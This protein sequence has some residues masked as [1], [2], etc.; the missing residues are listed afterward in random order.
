MILT[1]VR[2]V[3]R[4]TIS[5]LKNNPKN[6]QTTPKEQPLQHKERVASRQRSEEGEKSNSSA[7]E[8]PLSCG[9]SIW[10]KYQIFCLTINRCWNCKRFWRPP[11][12]V[13]TVTFSFWNKKKQEERG[14]KRK[15]NGH[16]TICLLNW[17][18]KP[19]G[20]SILVINL[21]QNQKYNY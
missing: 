3:S 13:D 8:Q 12:C 4:L 16:C 14:R 18:T 9:C 7:V 21:N 11:H 5:G 17:I 1:S 2:K 15:D 19:D 6:P 10:A 20:Q